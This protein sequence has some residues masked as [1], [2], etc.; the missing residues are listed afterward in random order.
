[1]GFMTIITEATGLSMEALQEE[2]AS[3]STLAEIITDVEALKA[4]LIEAMSEMPNADETGLEGRV[5]DLLNNPFPGPGIEGR[6]GGISGD[7]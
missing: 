5:S 6:P 1:M 3:G 2:A 4:E 7:Q